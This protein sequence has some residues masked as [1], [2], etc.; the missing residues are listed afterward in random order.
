MA[1][2]AAAGAPGGGGVV[3]GAWEDRRGR[4]RR[5]RDASDFFGGATAHRPAVEA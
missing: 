2:S 4:L 5:L 3:V 1:F